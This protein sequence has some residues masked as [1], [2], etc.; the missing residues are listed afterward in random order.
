VEQRIELLQVED[1]PEDAELVV[2][3]LERAGLQVHAQRVEEEEQMRQALAAQSW[4]LVIADY[5]LPRFS[6]PDALTLYRQAG[7]DIPFLV[8]SG[9][10]GEAAAVSMMKAGAHDYLLKHQLDRLAPAVARELQEAAVRREKREAEAKLRI[11][12]SELESIYANAPVLMFVV[13]ES[14]RVVKSNEMAA[15]F[16]AQSASDCSGKTVCEF[17]RCERR[18]GESA[19]PCMSC[20]LSQS[21]RRAL[22]SEEAFVPVEVSVLSAGREEESD[23]CL[24]VSAAPIAAAA[25]PRRVL[26]CAQDMTQL[27]RA[28]RSLEASVHELRSALAENRVLFQEVHHRVKNNLQI[29]ASL[30]SMKARKPSEELGAEDLKDC[31]RRIRSMAMIHEQLYGQKEM[32]AVDFAQYAAKI[33]PD[34]I[35][36]YEQSESIRP[37]LELSPALLTLDQSV[38]CGLI[39]NELVT[40]AVK[41]AYPEHAGEIFV[42]VRRDRDQIELIVAD[43]GVGM[44]A[45][46]EN[47]KKTSL[48]AQLMRMLTKQLKGALEFSGPPGVTATLRFPAKAASVSSGTDAPPEGARFPSW[49]NDRFAT[50]PKI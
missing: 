17:L 20:S 13:D 48:G 30:L 16:C 6:A 23:D 21:I 41:Y 34:L 15:R 29:V 28:E 31:E 10:I 5:R 47:E 33:V 4:D 26:I 22:N 7:L 36:S 24:L 3:L 14:L 37:R 42:R 2:R 12:Y 43:Q 45:A 35:A 32:Q 25:A 40:N 9:T 19:A 50:P 18:R 38:P 46:A 8:V 11:A 49:D 44:S 39:L 1:S 27:K